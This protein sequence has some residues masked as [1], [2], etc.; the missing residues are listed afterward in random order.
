MNKHIV[1]HI[2]GISGVANED[3][4][5]RLSRDYRGTGTGIEQTFR[6]TFHGSNNGTGTRASINP[7][8]PIR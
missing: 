2:V 4:C 1:K 8:H 3:G 6:E 7:I 5:A